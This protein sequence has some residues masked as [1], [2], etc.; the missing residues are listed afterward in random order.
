MQQPPVLKELKCPNCGSPLQQRMPTTQTL[1]CPACKSHVAIGGEELAILGKGTQIPAPPFP[2]F[3]GD[4]MTIKGMNFFVMGRVLYRGWDAEEP[5]DRWTWNEWL[6]GSESGKLMW[7]SYDPEQGFYLFEK[8]KFRGEF[9]PRSD[10]YLPLGEKEYA[11][12]T[13]RYPGKIVAAEGEL[14][15]QAKNGDDVFMAEGIKGEKRYSIQQT[16]AE[17]EFYEGTHIEERDVAESFGHAKWKAQLNSKK[18]SAF[19]YGLVGWTAIVLSCMGLCGAL[20]A[21]SSGSKMYTQTVTLSRERPIATIPVQF[22]SI[23]RPAKVDLK[24]QN[25]LT[26]N[27]YAEV[28]VSVTRPDGEEMFLLS[29]DFWYETGYDEGA[30]TERDYN[31]TGRFVPAT[32]GTYNLE[33]ELGEATNNGQIQVLVEVYRNHLLYSW[34]LCYGVIIGLIALVALYLWYMNF[35]SAAYH[36]KVSSFLSDMS[37]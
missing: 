17:M 27:T 8:L 13:E 15:W 4:R 35:F 33:V 6:M 3:P 30:W 29:K 26:V 37:D 5:S 23:G 20:Y 11:Q 18:Q 1:V 21:G 36:K 14:T 10:A 2:I 32:A 12:I 22:D 34:L 28:E 9:N 19:W 24:V 16:E 31:G 25:E 7:L